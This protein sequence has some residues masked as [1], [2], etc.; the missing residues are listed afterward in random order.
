MSVAVH[1]WAAGFDVEF[2][3]LEGRERFDLLARKDGIELEVDCKTASGDVGRPVHR[4]RALEL[5]RRIEPIVK[6]YAETAD[7]PSQGVA[8]RIVIPASLHGHHTYMETLTDLV[9]TAIQT[10]ASVSSGA[11]EVSITY[12]DPSD[13]AFSREAS[14]SQKQLGAIVDRLFGSA[15]VHAMTI[16]SPGRMALVVVVE[17]RKPDNMVDG[18]YRSLKDSASSQFSGVRPAVLA[19][20]LTDLT[21]AQLNDLALERR[22]G[23]TAIS[24]RLL[25]PGSRQHLFG[26]A[27]LAPTGI[28]EQAVPLTGDN[29]MIFQDR[30]IA[31][32]FKR[33]E[34]PMSND[35]RLK[36][37]S[38]A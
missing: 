23:L 5:F 26:V 16:H 10:G 19:T 20:R 18:I 27:F 6:Q 30:G 33:Q 17:S 36:V 22:T 11:E 7:A 15:G 25:R 29:G 2:T 4:S 8:I 13:E 3:D 31:L 28:L 21:A 32:M 34:H 14:A 12:F 35:P 24:N 9:N 1:L 37:F 38:S